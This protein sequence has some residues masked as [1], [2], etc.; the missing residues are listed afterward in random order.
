MERDSRGL[1]K[2]INYFSFLMSE[3]RAMLG[4]RIVR[5]LIRFAFS[6]VEAGVKLDDWV[7]KTVSK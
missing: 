1:P 7:I 4:P 2:D 3:N 6:G 5:N